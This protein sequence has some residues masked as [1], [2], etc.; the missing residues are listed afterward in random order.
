[1]Y[2][3][4]WWIMISKRISLSI[5][6]IQ[7]L[8]HL[9]SV[10]NNK[11]H[12]YIQGIYFRIFFIIFSTR[13]FLTQGITWYFWITT[14]V[15]FYRNM[16]T[17]CP[18]IWFFCSDNIIINVNMWDLFSFVICFFICVWVFV[19]FLYLCVSMC[20]LFVCEYV[21]FFYLC[22][23]MCFSLVAKLRLNEQMSLKNQ[24]YFFTLKLNDFHN[25]KKLPRNNSWNRKLKK[26]KLKF[27]T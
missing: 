26:I 21:C 27:M 3:F 24:D 20:F 25:K 12:R 5:I 14:K 2:P 15:D 10:I 16:H 6:Y 17:E 11:I 8:Q 7:T 9:K 22:V 4:Q 23:S 18:Q 19:F 13:E 1:M